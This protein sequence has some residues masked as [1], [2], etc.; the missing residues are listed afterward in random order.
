M[1]TLLSLRLQRLGRPSSPFGPE[2]PGF[3]SAAG[4]LERPSQLH[5]LGLISF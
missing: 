2:R 5:G 3:S 1:F 4:S